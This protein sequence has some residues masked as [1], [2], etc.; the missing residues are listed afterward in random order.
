MDSVHVMKTRQEHLHEFE[1]MYWRR[2]FAL[3]P[4]KTI[5]AKVARI[6]KA[7][8]YV[9]LREIGL[10]SLTPSGAPFVQGEST[11]R[12]IE[13]LRQIVP[14]FFDSLRD[15]ERAYFIELIK[16]EPTVVRA[17]RI[18]GVARTVIYRRIRAL[19]LHHLIRWPGS[20]RGNEM[21]RALSD[22]HIGSQRAHA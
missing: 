22:K 18:A 19:G 1:Q 17:A 20:K 7:P 2:L 16:Q 3:V 13:A 5:G 6:D 12:R 8:M 4:N 9:H 11:D 15:S 14:P 10:T 21:W